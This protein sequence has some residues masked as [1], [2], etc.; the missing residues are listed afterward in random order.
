MDAEEVMQD[1]MIKY[2]KSGMSLELPKEEAWLVKS[3]VRGAID[4]L[5]KKKRDLEFLEEYKADAKEKMGDVKWRDG[6]DMVPK[7]KE[8]MARL[9]DG[10]RAVLSMILFE[11]FDYEE[12]AQIMEVK[13]STVRSQYMRGKERLIKIVNE[14]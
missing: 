8:G 14:L 3:T 6:A 12:V 11:G 1:A 13:E 10:Y 5:R 4:R 2:L 7:I 9:P